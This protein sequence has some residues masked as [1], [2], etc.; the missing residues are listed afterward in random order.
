MVCT[1]RVCVCVFVCVCVC[2]CVCVRECVWMWRGGR[3]RDMYKCVCL[4]GVFSAQEFPQEIR[5]V[6]QEGC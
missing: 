6:L 3:T 1:Y 4:E 2:E 5:L